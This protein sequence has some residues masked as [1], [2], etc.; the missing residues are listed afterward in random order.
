MGSGPTAFR[1]GY[2]ALLCREDTCATSAHT[3]TRTTG[4]TRSMGLSA[5][6]SLSGVTGPGLLSVKRG[7]REEVP[8]RTPL[9]GAGSLDPWQAQRC[10]LALL[11]A[12][13]PRPSQ[14]PL[15]Q[16][17]CGEEGYRDPLCGSGG[18]L[19][20]SVSERREWGGD[21]TRREVARPA[22]ASWAEGGRPVQ[23]P[24]WESWL[25]SCSSALPG[26]GLPTHAHRQEQRAR[27]SGHSLGAGGCPR[28]SPGRRY[29]A[30][31]GAQR[32]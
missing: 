16:R 18:F 2:G 22:L 4:C 7:C 25:C 30:V 23:G 13:P 11:R 5:L 14:W 10:S 27:G 26:R 15:D 6:A 21:G 20:L 17:G 32:S 24:G 12:C 9:L 1:S 3:R 29:L 19:S 8:H 31:G 28:G